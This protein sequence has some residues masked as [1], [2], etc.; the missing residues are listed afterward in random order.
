MNEFYS[1][2][3][4]LQASKKLEEIK[5]LPALFPPAFFYLFTCSMEIQT[6]IR[7]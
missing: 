6:K 2:Q 1:S 7:S 4:G 5:F 3:M